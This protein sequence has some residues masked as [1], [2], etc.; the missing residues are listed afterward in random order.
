[1]MNENRFEFLIDEEHADERIDSVLS[2]LLEDCSRSYVVKLIESGH[3]FVNQ[4][5]LNSKKEKL[6]AGS[7]VVV[8]LPELA[9]C[10]ALPE[11]VPVDIVYE[12]DSVV[13]VNKAKGIVVHPAAGN[14]NGTLVNGLLY[15]CKALSTIN[16]VERPGIV[17]RIDK[18]TSGL[19]VVAKTDIAHR[20]L[21]EQFAAHS[22][23]RIYT[24]I[25]FY[26]LDED[27]TVD[28]PIGRDP[29]NRLRMAVVPDGKRAVTHIK[30]VK[31]YKGFTEFQAKL[32]TGRTHQIRVHMAYKH[33]PLLGD[34]LY[35][36]N[37]QPYKTVGQMLHAGTLGFVHPTTGE[38][39]EFNVDP[40]EEFIKIKERLSN[41]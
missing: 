32:E 28:A 26:R 25:C 35:G 6:K 16:G 22:I 31:N 36:P 4:N 15:H 37:N 33:H 27:F 19:L 7:M 14:L 41:D 34:A 13:V 39:I 40:P 11:D 18:D 20:N 23:N 8:E 21:S 24:G 9:S 10:E 3:V 38:Y 2:S 1:M 5:V 29:K 12:D 30:V 17:H